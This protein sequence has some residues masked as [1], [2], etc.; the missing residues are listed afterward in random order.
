[1]LL[2]SIPAGNRDRFNSLRNGAIAGYTIGGAMMLTGTLLWIFGPG[3]E[4]WAKRHKVSFTPSFGPE[5]V[6]AAF[7][8]VW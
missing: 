1:M 3:D 5:G 8:G 7:G 4:A 6:G 2:I